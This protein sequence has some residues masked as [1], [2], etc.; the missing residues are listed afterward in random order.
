[1]KTLLKSVEVTEKNQLAAFYGPL[2][3]LHQMGC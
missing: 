1:V 2:C 3:I